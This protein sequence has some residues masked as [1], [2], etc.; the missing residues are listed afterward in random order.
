[1]AA[2]LLLTFHSRRDGI[3]SLINLKADE[4]SCDVLSAELLLAGH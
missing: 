4:I 2:P 3:C 1:M